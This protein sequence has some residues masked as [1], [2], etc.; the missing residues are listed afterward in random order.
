MVASSMMRRVLTAIALILILP[1]ASSDGEIH[2]TNGIITHDILCSQIDELQFDGERANQSVAYQV[3]L[4][5]RIPQSNAS[6][7]LRTSISENLTGWQVQNQS[8]QLDGLEIVNLE[9]TLNAG[10]G[11][12]VVLMAHYDTRQVSDQEEDSNLSILPVPGAND[13]ASG[14]AV[15]LELAR[16]I[17]AMNL[18]HEIRLVFTDVE[19]QGDIAS[20]GV[21]IPWASGSRLWT[22]NLTVGEIENISSLIVVDM[23]GD[24][25]LTLT[26]TSPGNETMWQAVEMLSA[27]LGMVADKEDCNGDN[28]SGQMD[29]STT[30]GI[31][32]D[33]TYPISVGIPAI[34]IID[35]KYGSDEVLA[36]HWHTQNDSIDK[37]SAQSLQSVGHLVELGLRAQVWSGI[38][39]PPSHEIEEEQKLIT[40]DIA[41]IEAKSLDMESAVVGSLIIFMLFATIAA[42]ASV[43]FAESEGEL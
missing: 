29:T 28:G 17:P 20:G 1:I 39:E 15:L 34:D 25:N 16:H 35:V 41:E 14:V 43:I 27:S 6:S 22:E 19:D 33:H 18:S 32:D 4:G 5:P 37:V 3:G 30:I 13:G 2:T 9:A 10:A 12:I 7:I 36:G 11:K 42:V 8:H 31:L 38:S 23:V 21:S 26:R 24:S 40:D